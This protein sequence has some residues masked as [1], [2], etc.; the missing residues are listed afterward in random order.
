[1]RHVMCWLLLIAPTLVRGDLIVDFEDLGLPAESFYNGSD[2]AGG[3]TSRGVFF[4]NQY[5]PTYG[6]WSGIAAS[7]MTD[8]TNP[9]FTNQFSAWPGSGA[10]G[11]RTFAVS[12]GF[13]P[14]AFDLDYY[15]SFVNLPDNHQVVSLDVA[16]TTYAALT[17]RDGDPYGFSKKFGGPTGNDP[18]LFRLVILGFDSAFSDDGTNSGNLVGTVMVDLADYRFTDNRLDYILD[19]WLTVDLSGLAAARALG[20]RLETTDVGPFGPN[21][22]TYFAFDNLRLRSNSTVVPEP[23]TLILALTGLGTLALRCDRRK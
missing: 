13:F 1:M 17:I 18:D 2:G 3:F 9:F 14:N 7:T 21:T 22:P 12:F 16:N 11:S 20:F 8:T 23:A 4:R 5:N 15:E 19:R 10:G 6:S